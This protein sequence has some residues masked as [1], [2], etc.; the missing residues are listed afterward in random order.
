M[1]GNKV[2]HI[3]LKQF[4]PVTFD[5]NTVQH[6]GWAPVHEEIKL[7][8]LPI[9]RFRN[10]FRPIYVCSQWVLCVAIVMS[11]SE[12]DCDVIADVD[13]G[14]GKCVVPIGVDIYAW[15]VRFD[16]GLIMSCF[17]V[18]LKFRVMHTV[19]CRVPGSPTKAQPCVDLISTM[20]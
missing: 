4:H 16:S 14:W 11:W 8:E 5:I 1:R 2:C 13:N 6:H 12:W 20:H 17:L 18:Y 19:V 9:G 3:L 10:D 7:Y 15:N